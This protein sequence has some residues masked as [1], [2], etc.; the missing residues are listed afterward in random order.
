MRLFIAAPGATHNARN[1]PIA[2][3]HPQYGHTRMERACLRSLEAGSARYATVRNLLQNG[4]ESVGEQPEPTPIAHGNVRG[5][6]Y[7][8]GAS[9]QP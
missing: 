3:S 9:N 1:G 2:V 5:S 7:Y 6:G 8:A 4:M